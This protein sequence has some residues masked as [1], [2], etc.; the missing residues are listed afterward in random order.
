MKNIVDYDF[1]DFTI[2]DVKI[3]KT[4]ITKHEKENY[5]TISLTTSSDSNIIQSNFTTLWS[6]IL[7][8]LKN[9]AISVPIQLIRIFFSKICNYN[10]YKQRI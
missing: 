6:F 2:E 10:W 4:E 7:D 8:K 1:N 9:N 3:I 5:Y